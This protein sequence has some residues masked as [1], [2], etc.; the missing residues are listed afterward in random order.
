MIHC[1]GERD[2]DNI[3][4]DSQTASEALLMSVLQK[5]RQIY[6]YKLILYKINNTYD[7]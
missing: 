1:S 6:D 7:K 2:L 5:V 3:D 4:K